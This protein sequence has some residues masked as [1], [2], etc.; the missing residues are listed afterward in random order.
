MKSALS[1]VPALRL[2]VPFIIG[3]TLAESFSGQLPI[4]LP[5]L[6][7]FL[8]LI[9]LNFSGRNA[10]LRW[11]LR[12]WWFAAVFMLSVSAG[13]LSL[14]LWQPQAIELDKVNGSMATGIVQEISR[15]D[16]SMQMRVTLCHVSGHRISPH[17]ILVSTRGCD[18][19]LRECDV[20]AFR[21]NLDPITN[22]GNPDEFS[23][24]DV[25]WQQ[26]MIYKQ[27]LAVSQLRIV[28][29]RVS[30]YDM[31]MRLRRA[32][33]KKLLCTSLSPPARDLIVALLL[34]QRQFVDHELQ[35]QFSA[36]GVAHVLALSGLHVG[37]LAGIIWFLLLPLD[38]LR[39]KKLRLFVTVLGLVFFA[40]MTGLSL[41]VVRAVIMI[42]CTLV[43]IIL[44]RKSSALNA[45]CMS[46]LLTLVIWPAAIY[47][48]SFQLSYVTV[49]SIIGLSG[50]LPSVVSKSRL[51]NWLWSL[52]ATSL[53][54]M[55][56]TIML[57]AYYFNSMSFQSIIS[58]VLILPVMPLFMIAAIAFL[59]SAT[60]GI[61]WS[62]L[63]LCIEGIYKYMN[64]VS[65]MLSDFPYF[66]ID[67]IYVTASSVWIFYAVLLALVAWLMTRKLRWIM[68]SFLLSNVLIAH[69]VYVHL[70]TPQE[71][72]M[73]LNNYRSTPILWHKSGKGY[74]WIPDDMESDTIQFAN[75]IKRLLAH[76]SI[77]SVKWITGESNDNVSLVKPPFAHVFGQR[78]LVAA[79]GVNHNWI[80]AAGNGVEIDWIIVTKRFHG[81]L[82][83]LMQH[84]SCRQIIVSGSVSDEN[85]ISIKKQCNEL[86]IK[87]YDL[88]SQGAW[89]FAYH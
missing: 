51:L 23:R 78:I 42:S 72:L 67:R 26:G 8:T 55:L 76:R 58:N 81:S 75:S 48:A 85:R 65:D 21:C 2:L 10:I 84:F 79:S 35:Q 20:I 31:A 30:L 22:L 86:G 77:M 87:C 37:L 80:E 49:A 12:P 88:K 17:D 4:L 52:V 70:Q 24:Q 19:Q 32:L 69:L 14:R 71:E 64:S 25:Y 68:W 46:A 83:E 63:N 28:G 82:N 56:A 7:G 45:L 18:Y 44:Y 74:I 62:V 73:V 15:Y 43:A 27:H 53:I 6:I 60:A 13:G 89:V 66:H 11:R 61:E 16:F 36:A 41:S 29:H 5:G 47:Q 3:I 38:Y 33:T 39:L 57:T 1:R 59:V 34:N 54:A 40:F 9:Y 50:K